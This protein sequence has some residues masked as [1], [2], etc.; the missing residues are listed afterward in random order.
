MGGSRRRQYG[1]SGSPQPSRSALYPRPRLGTSRRRRTMRELSDTLPP[2]PRPR[3]PGALALAFWRDATGT[4]LRIAREHGDVA[5]FRFGSQGEIL[6]NHPDLIREVLVG[7]QRSFMKGQALQVAK[8]VLGEGLLTSEDELHLRQRRLM[9]P[10]FHGRRVAGYEDGVRD[11]CRAGAGLLAGRG[12]R[13]R[14]RGDDEAHARHRRPHALRRGRHGRGARDRRGVDRGAGGRQPP[15][16]SVGA[17]ARPPA[18]TRHAALPAGVRPAGR[19]DLPA[20]RRAARRRSGGLGSALSAARGPGRGRRHVRP[21]GQ[22]RG[23]DALPRRPRDDGEP[24]HLDALPAVAASSTPRSVWSPSSR[25]AQ[26]RRRRTGCSRRRCASTRR[27][28]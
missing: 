20:D 22:G 26:R 28:G 23:H 27:R 25:R 18:A 21:P 9:Q 19:H 14:A 3:V 1:R 4:L 7:E 5:G 2:G 8:R 12:R 15:G 11:V 6:L 13:G 17:A 16:L 10:L 24:A